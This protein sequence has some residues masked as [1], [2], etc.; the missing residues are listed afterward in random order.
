MDKQELKILQILDEIARQESVRAM[1]DSAV[2]RVERRLTQDFGALLAW[3]PVPLAT[4]GG[5]LPNM[6]RSS[7]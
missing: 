5:R 2:L 3:E 6:I 1:I 7:W 4:Y